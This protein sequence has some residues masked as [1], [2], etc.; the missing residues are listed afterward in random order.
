MKKFYSE[1]RIYFEYL[2][3][4][5]GIDGLLKVFFMGMNSRE[6][7]FLDLRSREVSDV[8][9]VLLPVGVGREKHA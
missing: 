7:M 5:G 2:V 6:E 1:G 4:S 8:S 3:N 9:H